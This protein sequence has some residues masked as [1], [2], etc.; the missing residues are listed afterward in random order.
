MNYKRI[1]SGVILFP[2]MAV[3]FIFGNTYFVDILVSIIAI[4]SLHEFYKAFKTKAKTVEAVG[5][6]FALMLAII[7]IIPIEIILKVIPA[8]IPITILVLFLKIILSNMETNI[9]DI[10]ITFF[11]I[12]Y[13]VIFMIFIPLIRE[14]LVNGKIIIWYVFITAWGTDTFAYAIGKKLGKHKFT[15]VSPNKTIEGCI[16]GIVG[17]VILSLIYTIICNKIWNLQINYIYISIVSI[18]LSIIGQIG[19]LAESSIKR[20]TEIKDSGNLIPGHGGMLDRIDSV[21]FIAPFAY[22]LLSLI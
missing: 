11:G 8:I 13:I 18:I 15:K 16:G 4:I 9:K 12:C 22:F 20:Y 10:S 2:I 5:Y 1:L 3:I 14:N 17:S 19:D 7:H 6:L 21:L